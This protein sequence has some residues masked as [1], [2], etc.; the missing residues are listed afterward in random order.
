MEVVGNSL[1]RIE[2]V[3]PA[4]NCFCFVYADEAMEL[5]REA[6][7]AVR[8]GAALGRPGRDQGPHPDRRQ[9]DDDGLVRLR[10]LGA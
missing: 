6:E 9:A 2:E 7:R 10:A 4:L 5:A 8:D 3:N 1:A